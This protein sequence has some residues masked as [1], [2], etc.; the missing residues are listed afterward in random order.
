M[1]NHERAFRTEAVIL[2]R[3][4][5]GE[6]D[7]LLT[8]LTPAHGKLDVI[9]KGARKPTASKT[10]HVELF[11]RVDMLIH[12]GRTFDI[13][14]QAVLIE[15]YLALREDLNRGAYANYTAELLD[16]FTML[17]EDDYEALFSLIDTT[18]QYL[19]DTD[20]PRLAARYYEIRLL[21]IV[22]F[23]PELT[24]CVITGE[25]IQPE[26]Q[27]ISYAE[28]GIVSPSAARNTVGL[29]P[30]TLP[31]LK[32]LRY[33]QRSRYEQVRHLSLSEAVHMEAERLLLG[34]ITAILERHLQSVD[35]IRRIRTH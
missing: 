11:T 13:A 32:L 17:G 16:R 1:P 26:D 24:R 3:R 8:V 33:M 7:R 21:D 2:K 29:V 15:P 20:D 10:G 5:F 9:A 30:I 4:D 28:G 18:F 35:F 19:C 23:R 25:E 6:A 14:T 31:T 12:R 27:F 34:Y 22:G